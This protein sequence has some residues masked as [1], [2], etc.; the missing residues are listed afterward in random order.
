MHKEFRGIAKINMTFMYRAILR[1]DLRMAYFYA[2][3]VLLR[4][5]SDDYYEINKLYKSTVIGLVKVTHF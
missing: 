2:R 3:K 5:S 4:M 1:L